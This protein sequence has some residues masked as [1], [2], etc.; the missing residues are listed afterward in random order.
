MPLY[1]YTC[2]DCGRTAQFLGGPADR[3]AFC[4]CRGL[5]LRREDIFAPCFKQPARDDSRPAPEK[6]S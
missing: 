6:S 3:V 4:H 5:M 1:D 2:L